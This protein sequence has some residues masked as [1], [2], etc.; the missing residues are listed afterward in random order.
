MSFQFRWRHKD[1]SIVELSEKGWT[2]DD[3]EKDAWLNKMSAGCSPSPALTLGIRIW[4]RRNCELVES[5]GVDEAGDLKSFTGKQGDEFDWTEADTGNA[6]QNVE[7][8]SEE[9]SPPF[10]RGGRKALISHRSIELA[11]QEFFRSR[12]M[13]LKAGFNQRLKYQRIEESGNE[14]EY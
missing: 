10:R 9:K 8:P 12:G 4:L 5:R 14:P 1:G 11:C 7:R 13:P 3:P 2:A 6:S